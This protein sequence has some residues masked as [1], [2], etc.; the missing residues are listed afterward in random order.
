MPYR[1]VTRVRIPHL[2]LLSRSVPFPIWLD[3][4]YHS[5]PACPSTPQLHAAPLTLGATSYS[6]CPVP[7]LPPHLKGDPLEHAEAA[8]D[9]DVVGRQREGEG[10]HHVPELIHHVLEVQL[11]HG[12]VQHVRQRFREGGN[13]RGRILKYR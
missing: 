2:S 13:D 6:S 10:V 5:L 12:G 9:G 11:R 7:F 4:R 3:A 8:D 1:I